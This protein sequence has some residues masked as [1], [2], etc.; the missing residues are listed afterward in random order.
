MSIKIAANN[1]LPAD[2]SKGENQYFC[3][4][5][6]KIPAVPHETLASITHR[7]DNLSIVSKFTPFQSVTLIIIT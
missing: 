4:R 1:I 5:C 6:E 7:T 3:K 2:I